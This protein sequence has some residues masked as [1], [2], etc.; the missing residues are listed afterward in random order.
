MQD[1]IG[2]AVRG[3]SHFYKKDRPALCDVNLQVG[4]GALGL[5]GP[6]GAGK[7]TLVRVLATTLRPTAGSLTLNGI[8][9]RR[10]LRSYRAQIGYLPQRFGFLPHFSLHE[11][12]HYAAWLKLVPASRRDPAVNY[13]LE[14]TS[15]STFAQRRMRELSGGM[16]R[17]A[18]I[19]QAI[20]N[21]PA[22]LL[23]DEPTVGLDPDQRAQL[24]DVLRYLSSHMAVVLATHLTEDVAA[25]CQRVVIVDKGQ[26]CFDGTP[27]ALSAI[28]TEADRGDSPIERGYSAVIARGKSK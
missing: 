19:A 14:A 11:F 21:D 25:V 17:R 10:S 20:V 13:A 27:V 23:L 12:L 6:N 3:L 1:D 8:E 26:T 24:R 15:L 9:A 4:I 28:A 7:T 5:L 18:G 22:V 2:L 16:L